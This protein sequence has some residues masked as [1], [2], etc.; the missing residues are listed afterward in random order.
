MPEH[1]AAQVEPQKQRLI[2]V[3]KRSTMDLHIKKIADKIGGKRGA[4]HF[5]VSFIM[6]GPI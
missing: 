6:P 5:H 2:E 1:F 4:G 3:L